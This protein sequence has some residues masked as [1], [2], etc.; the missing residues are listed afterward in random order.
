MFYGPLLTLFSPEKTGIFQKVLHKISG[1]YQLSAKG[2]VE[3]GN[4][5]FYSKFSV[6]SENAVL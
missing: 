6:F 2:H 1:Q 5:Y 3:A 4:N